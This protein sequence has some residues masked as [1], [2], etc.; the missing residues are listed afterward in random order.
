MRVL[1]FGHTSM[2]W[3]FEAY[4]LDDDTHLAS[5]RQTMVHID[6]KRRR[7]VPALPA[8]VRQLVEAFESEGAG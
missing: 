8:E 7:P 1:R 2:D 4:N 5:A 3:A 6:S